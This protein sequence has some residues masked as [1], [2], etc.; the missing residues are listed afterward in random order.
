M[1]TIRDFDNGARRHGLDEAVEDLTTRTDDELA[2]Y[3]HG[4]YEATKWAQR[5]ARDYDAW[6]AR[7]ADRDTLVYSDGRTVQA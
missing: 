1:N 6:I 3:L 2:E 7:P 4:K 5:A